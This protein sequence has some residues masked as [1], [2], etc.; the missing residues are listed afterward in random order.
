MR[1]RRHQCAVCCVLCIHFMECHYY[2][3]VHQLPQ[4]KLR[5]NTL[6]DTLTLRNNSGLTGNT[7]VGRAGRY[8]L[9]LSSVSTGT[10][11]YTFYVSCI[12]LHYAVVS[13]LYASS[14]ASLCCSKY[15][16]CFK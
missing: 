4:F 14:F 2:S 7:I 15:I 3:A 16:T 11:Y 12:L 8:K 5:N 6:Q 9:K 10:L 1:S 13:A